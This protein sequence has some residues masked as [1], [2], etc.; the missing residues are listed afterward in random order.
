M[1]KMHGSLSFYKLLE[2]MAVLHDK[3]S[4]DYAKDSDPYG[5]Y[6]F[7]GWIASL[8]SHSPDDA[9][10]AGR[11]AEKI[12]RL[13]VLEGGN[14]VPKNESIEDTERDIAVISVLWMS[15]RRDSRAKQEFGQGTQVNY[16]TETSIDPPGPS[17]P[18]EDA[19]NAVIKAERDM[20]PSAILETIKYLSECY[21]SRA[22]IN[23]S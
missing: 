2:E 18:E 15:A 7:A 20:S 17:N 6:K 4:H 22:K 10:F 16:D 1:N 12:F 21:H 14:L 19:V 13:S 23:I 9:G 8:F 3:K 5:N 11:L